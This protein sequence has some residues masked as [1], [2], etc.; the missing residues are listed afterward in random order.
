VEGHIAKNIWIMPNIIDVGER[1]KVGW[2]W[3]QDGSL[4][5]WDMG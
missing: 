4:R 2:V 5:S 3:K 1:Y